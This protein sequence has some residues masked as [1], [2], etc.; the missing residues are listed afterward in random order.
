MSARGVGI[1]AKQFRSIGTGDV[2]VST[3]GVPIETG[4]VG[5]SAAKSQCRMTG[6][7]GVCSGALTVWREGE[8]GEDDDGA[9]SVGTEW[10]SAGGPEGF[11]AGIVGGVKPSS[12][13]ENERRCLRL[14]LVSR[15]E[16]STFKV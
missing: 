8:V 10:P 2:S 16:P 4:N 12:A 6:P 15:P 1:S 11:G 9:D 7:G 3:V 5:I 14:R 13:G